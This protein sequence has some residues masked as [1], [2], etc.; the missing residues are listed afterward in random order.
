MVLALKAVTLLSLIIIAYFDFKERQFPWWA[1]ALCFLCVVSLGVI[2]LEISVFLQTSIVNVGFVL[3]QLSLLV[4]WLLVKQRR[5]INIV[6][7]YLGLG[8]ILFFVTTCFA[9]SFFNFIFY[10]FISLFI[11][12]IVAL[13]MKR[14]NKEVEQEIPAAG[15]LSVIFGLILL[16]GTIAKFDFYND[17]WV[18]AW[19]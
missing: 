3:V 12:L 2:Q 19:M 14:A 7:N 1:I 15:I 8:D 18:I 11:T 13:L 5:L 4:L 17:N 16:V 9:F 10:H 6:D